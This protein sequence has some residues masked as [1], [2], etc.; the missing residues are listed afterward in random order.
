MRAGPRGH[1]TAFEI[2][3]DLAGLAQRNLSNLKNVDL[4]HAD[5]SHLSG[6][7][8]DLIYV[9]CMA[10]AIP[11]GWLRQLASHG[12]LIFPLDVRRVVDERGASG[13]RSGWA[14]A[15]A[16]SRAA[17]SHRAWDPPTSSRRLAPSSWTAPCGRRSRRVAQIAC[18]ACTPVSGRPPT[19]GTEATTG[20]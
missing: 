10:Q 7:P 5:G 2:D 16:G 20:G 14:T 3:P 15:F 6:P 1:V 4:R 13:S 9:N 18:G 12:A 11:A 8:V 17:L 19:S